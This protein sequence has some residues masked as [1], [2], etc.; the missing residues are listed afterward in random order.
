MKP[1]QVSRAGTLAIALSVVIAVLGYAGAQGFGADVRVGADPGGTVAPSRALEVQRQL[2]E[3]RL[4]QRLKAAMGAAFGGLWYDRSA[5]QLHVG[6]TS[7]A[8]RDAAE[9][10]AVEAGLAP[11]V[12][13]TPVRSSWAELLAEQERLS[14]SLAD[15]FGSA[16]VA[17]GLASWSNSVEVELGSAVPSARREAIERDGVAAPVDVGVA[18]APVQH[19]R[20]ERHACQP[21]EPSEANCDPS[22]VAGVTIQAGT[23]SVCTAGPTVI[24]QNPTSAAQET[25]TFLLTAGHCIEKTNGVGEKWYAYTPAK[26]PNP[27]EKKEIGKAY[28]FQNSAADVGVIKIEAGSF[29]LNAGVTPVNPAIAPWKEAKPIPVPVISEAPPVAGFNSC[30]SGQTS[31]V[32]CGK[33]EKTDVE[34]T[35]KDKKVSKELAEVKGVIG[36]PGDSGAPWYSEASPGVVEGTDVGIITTGNDVFQPL[37]SSFARLGTE[38]QLLRTVNEERHV[39]RLVSKQAETTVTSTPD[40]GGTTGHHVFDAAGGSLTCGSAS[41][42]G[43]QTTTRASALTVSAAY[44]ECTFLGFA[45]TVSMG[46]CGF[47]F[48]ANGKFDIVSKA[49]KNCSTE[50]IKVETAACKVEVRPQSRELL[51]F[52]NVKPGPVNEV[53]MEMSVTGVVY[54]T[55]GFF[56]PKNGEFSDGAYTTGNT[57]LTATKPGGEMVDYSWE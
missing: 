2:Q 57:L 26:P 11:E 15:L 39:K 33:V 9:A 36:F 50:P 25:E 56:C 16:E 38:Y 46:G 55:S 18:V 40:G 35:W 30:F 34:Y 3:K 32:E 53:T 49:G 29:W 5:A 6:F 13:A 44:K 52:H 10:V 48:N 14:R 12:V 24:L 51:K 45:A 54:K 19:L 37:A 4:P 42:E 17:T 41:F 22:I 28:E 31:G 7:D 47:V 23:G 43:L 20:I 8:G 21:H 1:S 27:P